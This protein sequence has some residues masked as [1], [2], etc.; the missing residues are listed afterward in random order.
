M[1]PLYELSISLSHVLKSSLLSFKKDEKLDELN[2]KI[3]LDFVDTNAEMLKTHYRA[4]Q[5]LVNVNKRLEKEISKLR[6]ELDEKKVM[7]EKQAK[8]IENEK[9]NNR[10]IFQSD[11]ANQDPPQSQQQQQQS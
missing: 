8:L 1:T 11:Q 3:Q 6:G 5:S 7:L 2:Q 10:F 9:L 4:Y